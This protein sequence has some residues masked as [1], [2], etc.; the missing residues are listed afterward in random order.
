MQNFKFLK[1]MGLKKP[2][3]L[4]DFGK[5]GS[6]SN[7]RVITRV[8]HVKNGLNKLSLCLAGEEEGCAGQIL[9]KLRC[10]GAVLPPGALCALLER[11]KN[12]RFQAA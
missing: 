11:P 12:K 6:K 8:L 3:F 9:H 1:G 5:V 10:T 7:C 2:G 4:P